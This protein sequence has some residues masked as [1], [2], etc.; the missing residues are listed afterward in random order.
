MCLGASIGGV[1]LPGKSGPEPIVSILLPGGE[2]CETAPNCT[3]VPREP[4]LGV[5]GSQGK[6]RQTAPEP[7]FSILLLQ[8][9]YYFSEKH[10]FFYT[11]FIYE[12]LVKF[13]TEG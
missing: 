9:H 2:L 3:R 13:G 1:R 7:E 4:P 12:K 5:C 6:V 11:D 8:M 10:S